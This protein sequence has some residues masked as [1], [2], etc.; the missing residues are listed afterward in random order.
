VNF[1]RLNH[2]LIPTTREDRER[3]RRTKL[4]KLLVPVNWLYTAFT[5]EGR[6]LLVVTLFVG[7]AGLEVDRTAVYLLWSLLVGLLS[8]CLLTRAFY[9]LGDVRLV[10]S[11]PPRVSVDTPLTINLTVIND[12][13]RARGGIRIRGPFLPWDGQFLQRQPRVALLEPGERHRTEIKA[14]FV[15]RG[16]H[17]IDPFRAVML[18][19]LGLSVGPAIESSTCKFVVIPRIAEVQSIRLP[20]GTSYQPGG[21]A[22]ASH[23]GE[24]M[25][26]MG[27][28][29]YRAGDPVRDLHPKTW[30]RTGVPHVREYQQ[31]YFT[32]IGII[33]DTDAS[34]LTE[35]G[36]EAAISLAAGVLAKLTRGE[37]LIDVLM[38]GRQ[39]HALTVGRSLSSLDQALDV[40][41]CAEAGSSLDAQEWMQHLEPYVSRLS[42]AVVITQS[43]DE[44]RL[45]LAETLSHRGVSPLL[46]RIHDDASRWRKRERVPARRNW[47]R[48]LDV[49]AVQ[50]PEGL[51]L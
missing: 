5:D 26:L 42:A 33:V 50:A 6:V 19:P 29:P 18:A 3:F 10:V 12:G 21:I 47:E 37:A 36:F 31:E 40:L 2:I 38:V 14:L 41:A 27:V 46:L 49:S 23:T 48:V 45:L 28:R 15:Q 16:H 44:S 39:L 51:V 35:E 11:A 13:E 43:A 8:G 4:A 20:M 24:A 30:A 1:A 34:S 7:T 9:R 17:H 32:R 25:E 22:H